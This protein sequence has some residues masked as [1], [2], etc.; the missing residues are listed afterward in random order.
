[1]SP[2]SP[3][4]RKVTV[5][6]NII[7]TYIHLHGILNYYLYLNVSV[8]LSIYLPGYAQSITG[9]WIK[10]SPVLLGVGVCRLP[11]TVTT[12]PTGNVEGRWSDLHT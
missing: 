12:G 4:T 10:L 8:C 9:C 2:K 3:Q 5:V 11:I 7:Y 6:H 1:M